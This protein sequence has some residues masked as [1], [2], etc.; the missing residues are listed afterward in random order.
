M[1]KSK[2]QNRMNYAGASMAQQVEYM[3]N[4]VDVIQ[5]YIQSAGQHQADIASGSPDHPIF[6]AKTGDH[7]QQFFK[8]RIGDFI[9]CQV[10][11]YAVDE[12]NQIVSNM[13]IRSI[14]E[15][16][17]V[18]ACSAF[19]N[20]STC[21]G[22]VNNFADLIENNLIKLNLQNNYF[23]TQVLDLC[24]SWDSNYNVLNPNDWSDKM[25]AD[26]PVL[27]QNDDFIDNLYKEIAAD[28]NKESRQTMKI[29]HFTDIHMDLFYRAGASKTC[30]D[31]I[32]CRAS[33]GFPKDPS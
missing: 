30:K 2:D 19:L 4:A 32:C 12:V 17:A 20:W 26:K 27:I 9:G 5:S 28:P 25:L 33:D 13:L 24:P 15:D 21:A 7:I 6:N 8:G 14:I 10:C 1:A 16:G 3:Q 18:L 29:V 23:C 22:F 31:V 11:W